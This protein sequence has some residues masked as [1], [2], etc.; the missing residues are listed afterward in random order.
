MSDY[1]HTKVFFPVSLSALNSIM[2][3]YPDATVEDDSL[4]MVSRG[5]RIGDFLSHI[6]RECHEVLNIEYTCSSDYYSTI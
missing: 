4:F 2:K 3:E 6:S 5:Y 1:L